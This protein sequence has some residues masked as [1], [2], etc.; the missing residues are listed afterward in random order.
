MPPTQ[1]NLEVDRLIEDTLVEVRES[2]SRIAAQ[3]NIH[4]RPCTAEV[5]EK[6]AAEKRRAMWLRVGF[7]VAL[8]VSL[9]MNLFL[10]YTVHELSHTIQVLHPQAEVLQVY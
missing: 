3:H 8:A 7:G 10:G 5:L 1:M 2:M 4:Y 6:A 9:A